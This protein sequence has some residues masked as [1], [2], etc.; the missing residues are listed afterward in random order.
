MNDLTGQNA[1]IQPG[2]TGSINL[3]GLVPPSTRGSTL[4]YKVGYVVGGNSVLD[5]NFRRMSVMPLTEVECTS[6][7]FCGN[8]EVCSNYMCAPY[9][10]FNSSEVP[11]PDM[12]KDSTYYTNVL[13]AVIAVLLLVISLKSFGKKCKPKKQHHE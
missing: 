3:Q 8:G 4:F 9:S 2:E 12:K 6:N 1:Q 7:D 10:L 13:L 5:N 11:K